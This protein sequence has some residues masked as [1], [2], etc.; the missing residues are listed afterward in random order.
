MRFASVN[1]T[2]MNCLSTAPTR[3]LILHVIFKQT[4]PPQR[5]D[6]LTPLWK[7]RREVSYPRHS[8]SLPSSGKQKVDN[9]A[10]TNLRFYPLSCTA[11]S[12]DISV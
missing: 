12:W 2:S 1:P 11:A 10:V 8:D 3:S 6:C 5:V 7:Y 9:L 4:K